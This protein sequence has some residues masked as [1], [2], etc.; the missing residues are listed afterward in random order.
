MRVARPA[1]VRA[2]LLAPLERG[3][4]G[5]RPGRRVVRGHDLGRPRRPA[6]RRLEQL[7]LHLVGQRDAVLHRQ[8]VERAGDRALHAGAVVAPDPDDER[9]VELAQLLDRVDAPG[10]RCGRRSPEKPG[11]DLHLAG[12][13]RLARL[14]HVVPGRER[15]VARRQLGVLRDHAELPSGARRSPRAACPSP[16][17]TCPCTCPPTRAATWCGAWLQPVEKYTKNGLSGLLGP[18]AVQPLDRLVGHGVRQVVRV[19]VA[20]ARGRR[21]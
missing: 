2:D 1:E 15:V 8:L 21:R 5:P 3:V 16:G 20:V 17:R 4:A 12:V 9:V 10:R 14:G 6:R 18:D 13:E 19:L 11:V 7:E